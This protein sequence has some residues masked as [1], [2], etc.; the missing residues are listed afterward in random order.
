MLKKTNK[1]F[2]HSYSSLAYKNFMQA[3]QEHTHT[4]I[5]I[6]K[7]IEDDNSYSFIILNTQKHQYLGNMQ[8]KKYYTFKFCIF[9]FSLYIQ[10]FMN[11]NSTFIHTLPPHY[12]TL[13]Q[14]FQGTLVYLFIISSIIFFSCFNLFFSFK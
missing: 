6:Y 5:H 4:Y 12:N 14:L 11:P 2:S 7:K 3:S 13:I 9:P 10:S 8:E 1:I